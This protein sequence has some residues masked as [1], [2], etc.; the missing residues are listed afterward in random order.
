MTVSE[1]ISRADVLR[2]NSVPEEV[3][4]GFLSDVEGEVRVMICKEDP[5][6][7]KPLTEADVG[8]VL[9]TPT[10]FAKLYVY[11]LCA[12]YAFYAQDTELYANDRA[13]FEKAW[14]D[15]AK[16]YVRTGGGA[17]DGNL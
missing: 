1:I 5:A 11:Y 4:R 15:Y 13:V 14:S 16:W 8:K 17:K 2:P 3:K 6:S 12:M 10:T 9:T 7:V